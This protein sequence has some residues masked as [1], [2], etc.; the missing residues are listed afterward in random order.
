MVGREQL[1]V[2]FRA[3][4]QEDVTLVKSFA[5]AVAEAEVRAN[6][7][8]EGKDFLGWYWGPEKN[9]TKYEGV[10]PMNL[11]DIPEGVKNAVG[12][13]LVFT[14]RFGNH[15]AA[16]EKEK[17]G[18]RLI[19][20]EDFDGESLDE[21]RWVDKYL[22]S[23]ST[24]A[25]ETKG[26][27]IKDG[28]M[29]LKITGETKP[30]CPE[31]DGQTV[32]S[33]FTTGQRNG[34][35]NWNRTN[36]VR[37]PE[38]TRLTHINQYGYYEMRAKGQSG[39]SRHSAWWLLGSEDVPQE[40][41]EIDIFEVLGRSDHAVP[42]ALHKWKDSDAFVERTLSTKTDNTKDFNNEYHVYG[43]DWQ[44]GTGS[45]SYPDKIVL[46]IDGEKYTETNVNIDYPMIRLLS[47]YEK[48]AGGWTGS[49]EWMPYPNTMDID[50]VRVYKKL[51]EGQSAKAQ[52]ELQIQKITAEDLKISQGNITL[53]T[54]GSYTEK[55][56][57]GT[58][59]YVRVQWN[60]GVETQ[61]PVVWEA[62]TEEDLQK[63]RAG[64]SIEKN[65]V[66]TITSLPGA[67]RTE[68]T[69]MAIIPM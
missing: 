40:S 27:E 43:F 25:E 68:A 4:G 49:W 13:R 41:A 39:S 5:G 32:I 16:N 65:G 2:T 24:T 59:S 45:G 51:P 69:K 3:E 60:D 66:V 18:Y 31:F 54:Y 67:Q 64:E 21:T 26:K 10:F 61:E 48:R 46:Y 1:L 23:W 9:P 50:Y 55:N 14:A 19:F 11:S 37:N 12:D 36:Q 20:D 44:Q 58:K 62:I 47:L 38:D 34:L 56:L 28:I 8:K 35:H 17:E 53:T 7:V 30:W 15:T 6:P 33:G 63:L 57:S 22:S 42:P 29:S 52:S